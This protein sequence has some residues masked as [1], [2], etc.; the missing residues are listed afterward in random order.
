MRKV[1]VP[2]T[3]ALTLIALVV[4]IASAAPC[5]PTTCAPLSVAT[6]GSRMLLVRP[7]GLFGPLTALDLATGKTAGRFPAGVLSADGR[8]FVA[9]SL[10]GTGTRVTR[11]DAT[12]GAQLSAWRFKGSNSGVAAVSAD[13][14][15]A[16]LVEGQKDPRVAVVDLDRRAVLRNVELSGQWQVDALSRDGSRLYL[17][18]YQPK[19]GY[20]VRVEQAGQGLVPGAITDPNDPEPMIGMPWSSIGTRDGRLQLTLFL[21]S[22]ENKTEAFIHALSLDRSEAACIDLSSGAFMAIGRYALVLAPN[23]R[24]LYAAN[25]SLGVVNVIDL[26]RRKVIST[27]RFRPTSADERT[28]A[29]FGAIARDGRTVYFSAGRGLHAYDTRAGTVRAL[30]RVGAIIGVGVDPS[31]KTLLV[32]RPDG[33]TLR[34]NAQTGTPLRA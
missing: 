32:V 30:H 7:Q 33:A 21:K 9:T 26:T 16:A 2:A 23:G 17:L 24:T 6:P 20:H 14:R 10:A 13:G 19:G 25:P 28:S 31:G 27:A 1:L 34:V 3:G 22:S 11:Y 29:A 5:G 4:G 8:R 18:E 12:T 15:F